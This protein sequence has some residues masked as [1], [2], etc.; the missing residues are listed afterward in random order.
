MFDWVSLSF[1]VAVLLITSAVLVFSKD[2][3]SNEAFFLRFHATLMRFA[4]SIILLIYRT[5]LVSIILGWDGLG[6]T[7][8]LL[9]IY[10]QRNKATNA[11]ILT[12][13]SNRVGDVLIMTG[14]AFRICLGNANFRV[15][16][17]L[18][19]SPW[20]NFLFILVLARLTKRAQIPF[21]AWL[22][23]AIAAPTPVSALVHSSTLVTAGI[24]LL[25]RFFTL[26]RINTLASRGV[27][28]I[29]CLT[30]VMAGA[31][32]IVEIDI[33][34]IVALSTLRQLGL[35]M[36]SL[37]LGQWSVRFFHLI[38]HAFIKALLFLSVGN[39]IHFSNDY[40]D[41]RKSK[42]LIY[43]SPLSTAFMA[44]AN[45]GLCGFPFLAG[46]YSK[47]LWLEL[48]IQLPLNYVVYL[49]YW[50]ATA[51]TLAYSAR[52][53][54][55]VTIRKMPNF[56]YNIIKDGHPPLAMAL[57]WLW[58]VSVGRTLN[59]WLFL[60]P[61]FLV[62]P[63]ELK[64]FI[65]LLV[66]VGLLGIRALFYVKRRKHKKVWRRGAMWGLPFISTPLALLFNFRLSNLARKALE[67]PPFFEQAIAG[68][69]FSP[70]F[71][72][73][74]LKLESTHYLT[75]LGTSVVLLLRLVAY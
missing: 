20:C 14:V 26:L 74:L 13:L 41:L 24:Y 21:S 55:Y 44:V 7:S 39:A 25:V 56:T 31:S 37:G 19:D 71:L 46:F 5:N 65:I 38:T 40:Q 52:F 28:I 42:L 3:M 59:R 54:Y 23:A 1:G 9:V 58:A 60:S 29:G 8:Y 36:T 45:L 33:K 62:L 34:K 69:L 51:L 43:K 22:P 61:P 12:A 16:A 72:T 48:R 30:I 66:S 2:Y 6:V 35:M 47:D 75:N 64:E 50:G 17:L 49:M 70:L 57:L 18:G 15:M 4:L 68:P 27:L 11:A 67:L 73:S 32:A 53:M 10:Y 63:L